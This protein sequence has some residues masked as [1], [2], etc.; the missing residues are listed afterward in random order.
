MALAG[1]LVE[2]AG[3]ERLRLTDLARRFLE[4]T[5]DARKIVADRH[6]RYFG[7]ELNDMSLT[8]GDGARLGKVGFESWFAKTALA[9]EHR[10]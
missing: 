2:I 8:P 3:P 7:V 6:A 10:R 9:H 4:A 1:D 5:K